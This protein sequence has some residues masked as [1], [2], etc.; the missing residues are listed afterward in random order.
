MYD[1]YDAEEMIKYALEDMNV[2]GYDFGYS[3]YLKAKKCK[4]MTKQVY[5]QFRCLH[6]RQNFTSIVGTL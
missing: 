4:R 1:S 2:Y 5:L 6:C 3:K